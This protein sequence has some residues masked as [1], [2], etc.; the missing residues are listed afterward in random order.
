MMKDKIVQHVVDKYTERSNVGYNK[1][2]TTLEDN[3]KDNYLVHLQEE[4]M[5]ATLYIQKLI[6]M[7][8]EITKLVRTSINDEDLGMKIRRLVS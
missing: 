4:L 7:D 1:Y 6:D 2:G 5:D 8:R 3:N